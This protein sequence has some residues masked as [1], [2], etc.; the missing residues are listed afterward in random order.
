MTPELK[1]RHRQWGWILLFFAGVSLVTAA[2]GYHMF[3]D[4][5]RSGSSVRTS[6]RVAG[7]Y[8]S[9]GKDGFPILFGGGALICLG[10]AIWRLV[11]GYSA[12]R[13]G[14]KSPVSTATAHHCRKCG[15][16]LNSGASFCR[17][18]REWLD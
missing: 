16:E 8:E 12:D 1:N 2:L 13:A 17:H 11:K 6:Q 4:A 3:D 9:F 15:G 7:I 14:G 5:E 10:V 18:C